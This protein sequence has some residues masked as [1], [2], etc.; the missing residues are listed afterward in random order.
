MGVLIT[1]IIF[2]IVSSLP[3]MF[4]GINIVDALFESISSTTTTGASIFT[5]FDYPKTLFFWRALT[6]WIGGMGII[7]LLQSI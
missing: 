5:H 3:Y 4:Y 6:Q 2:S 1:W 7:V